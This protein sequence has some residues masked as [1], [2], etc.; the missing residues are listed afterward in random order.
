MKMRAFSKH[1]VK[2]I[3]LAVIKLAGLTS[4]SNYYLKPF[5]VLVI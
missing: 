5:L 3:A 1:A 4:Y 2:E